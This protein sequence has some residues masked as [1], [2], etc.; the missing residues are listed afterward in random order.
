MCT[1]WDRPMEYFL[2]SDQLQ[3]GEEKAK[4]NQDDWGQLKQAHMCLL[5]LLPLEFALSSHS[6]TSFMS[7]Q[8]HEQEW[9]FFCSVLWVMYCDWFSTLYMLMCH[10]SGFSSSIQKRFWDQV[11]VSPDLDLPW[12]WW[13]LTLHTRATLETFS[14]SKNSNSW[15]VSSKKK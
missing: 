11:L 8:V 7:F 15:P 10:S 4:P 6:S 2:P 5:W 13:Q 3:G 12:F 9:G 1:L 14:F